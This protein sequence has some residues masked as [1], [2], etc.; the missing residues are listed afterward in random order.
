MSK[1]NLAVLVRFDEAH[2]AQLIQTTL[3]SEIEPF[4]DTL[5]SQ[6]WAINQRMFA[7]LSF[8]ENT[9]DYLCIAKGGKKV[10]TSKKRVDFSNFISLDGL[11]IARIEELIGSH[12]RGHF[13]RSSSGIG[14][15]IPQA[16]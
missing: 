13:I 10:A 15:A 7:L 8:S 6:D 3:D 16:T 12:L 5:S 11:L 1:A 4:S 14:G 9:L 2:R